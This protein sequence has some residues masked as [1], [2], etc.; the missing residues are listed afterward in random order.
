MMLDRDLGIGKSRFNLWASTSKTYALPLVCT[1]QQ[2]H[3]IQAVAAL[4]F[5]L[6]G[7][8]VRPSN[9]LTLT[10]TLAEPL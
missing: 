9:R 3:F 10:A 8:S 6:Q 5:Q 4:H 7:L 2:P 1:V